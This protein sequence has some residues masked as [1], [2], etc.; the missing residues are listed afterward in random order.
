MKRLSMMDGSFLLSEKPQQPM[1]VA[2]LQLF[3]LPEKNKRGFVKNLAEQLRAGGEV[4]APFNQHIVTRLGQAYWREDPYFDLDHHFRHLALPKPGR[5]RELLALVSHLHASLLDRSRP[6]WECY[7]IEG[8]EGNR[9]ALY[10]KMHHAM[11]DG[12]T[13]MRLGQAA[14]TEDPTITDL[15]PMWASKN[16]QGPRKPS[17]TTTNP[18][19][20][21]PLR[22]QDQIAVARGALGTFVDL[23]KSSSDETQITP[24]DAP[25]CMLNGPIS[26]SR[27]FAAQSYDIARIKAVADAFDATLN[28]VVMAMC[29]G[30]L[31]S[32][33]KSMNGLPDKPLIAMVPVSVKPKDSME[34]GNNVGMILASLGTDRS[35]PESRLD[36]IKRSMQAGKDR[37][38][39]M[40]R[41][42]I[43]AYSALLGMP[44]ALSVGLGVAR[45]VP[46]Y[47]VVISNVP[48]PKKPMYFNGAKMEGMYPVSIVA[49]G[50]AMNITLNSYVD[51][52]EFG[53]IA[54]R[55]SLPSIQR[56]LDYLEDELAALEKAADLG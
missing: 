3:S 47:N 17:G 30:A 42:E 11:V 7:L 55:R 53:V 36:I 22:L 27:R 15:P 2:G 43:M 18:S 40:S 10:T 37:F 8:L 13:A 49:E 39:Q 4:R 32:Y 35:A 14:M 9:F 48:G 34:A 38:S 5:V 41:P 45:D 54:C 28:D 25:R 33:L 24:M 51:K 21:P 20:T 44:L 31:R 56:I 23:W 12:V 46:M 19:P 26:A 50:Q 1:H 29:G 6:L 16:L 52:M